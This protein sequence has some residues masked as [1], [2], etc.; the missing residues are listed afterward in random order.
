MPSAFDRLIPDTELGLFFMPSV[1]PFGYPPPVSPQLDAVVFT[2][3][4]LGRANQ[5]RM[6]RTTYGEPIDHSGMLWSQHDFTSWL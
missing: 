3:R 6:R 1:L 4:H 5:V 2:D